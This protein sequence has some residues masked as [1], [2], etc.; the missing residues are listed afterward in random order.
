MTRGTITNKKT[1][2]KI[3]GDLTYRIGQVINFSID[4]TSMLNTMDGS[5][6]NFTPDPEPI[7]DGI[8]VRRNSNLAY[9]GIRKFREGYWRDAE[10]FTLSDQNVDVTEWVRLVPEEGE[11]K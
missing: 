4:G 9:C 7:K 1:G 2:L 3:R 10:G 6:W 8:Y 5:D 11:G